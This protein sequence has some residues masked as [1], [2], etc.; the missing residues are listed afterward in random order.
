[1]S[2][3]IRL[4]IFDGGVVHTAQQ[5]VCDVPSS[6]EHG[7]SE[8]IMRGETWAPTGERWEPEACAEG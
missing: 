5:S 7:S 4:Q 2:E 6:R 3:E 1:M 8:A